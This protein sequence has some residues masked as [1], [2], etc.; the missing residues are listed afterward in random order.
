VKILIQRLLCALKNFLR[1]ITDTIIQ[2]STNKEKENRENQKD[3]IPNYGRVLGIEVLM[4]R[5][6][7]AANKQLDTVWKSFLKLDPT[8]LFREKAAKKA[9][10]EAIWL[11]K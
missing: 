2:S 6:A 11:W 8:A 1:S 7:F 4:E 3:E 5:E 9:G 10:W